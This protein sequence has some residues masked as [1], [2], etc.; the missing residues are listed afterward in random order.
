MLNH[1]SN[2]ELSFFKERKDSC[3]SNI[4]SEIISIK[5]TTKQKYHS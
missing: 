2:K 3:I 4:D 1:I 5:I